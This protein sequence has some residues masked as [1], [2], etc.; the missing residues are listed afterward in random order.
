MKLPKFSL[1][2]AA[3]LVATSSLHAATYQW[4]TN[5]STAGL[6]AAGGATASWSGIN[7][8]LVGS[9]SDTG[10]AV[11]TAHNFTAGT[12]IALF[13]G[14]AGT[15]TVDQTIV[16]RTLQ[17]AADGYTL[18]TSNNLG[19]GNLTFN[20]GTSFTVRT[21]AVTGSNASFTGATA[22]QGINLTVDSLSTLG[23]GNITIG[24]PNGARYGSLIINELGSAI[25]T[26]RIRFGFNA[27][28]QGSLPTANT[29]KNNSATA[30]TLTLTNNIATNGGTNTLSIIGL[31]GSN[32]GNNTISGII[33]NGAQTKSGISKVDAGTWVLSG[34]NTYGGTYTQT[35][36]PFFTTNIGTTISAGKLITNNNSALGVGSVNVS[37][38]LGTLQVGDG[39]G[40]TVNN[41]TLGSTATL[42]LAADATLKL[43]G[44]DSQIDMNGGIFT[45][46]NGVNIDIT[47]LGLGVGSYILVDG[48][49]A[50][51]TI[52]SW[53]SATDLIGGTGGFTY[54]FGLTG[55]DAVLTV[56]PEPSAALLGG[57]GALALL[58]RRRSH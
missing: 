7:W 8:D 12:D 23:T 47:G 27:D 16:P 11:T 49:V 43:G 33:S 13:G 38:A 32:T 52:G 51:S 40:S 46:G 54:T 36:S 50:G 26:N 17:F 56:V 58:R 18:A 45:F 20:I 34:T 39:T 48:T 22:I 1:F 21:V 30:N 55:N 19:S 25:S 35:V 31:G 37:T 3:L 53:N 4:D 44:I 9:G 10:T 24:A 28:N 15:V 29:I 5:S 41:L 14:T 2:S 57:L 42:T 6:G